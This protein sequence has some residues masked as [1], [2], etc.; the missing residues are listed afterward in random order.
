MEIDKVIDAAVAAIKDKSGRQMASWRRDHFIE[1]IYQAIPSL[2]TS[3]QLIFL[4]DK[5]QMKQVTV[6]RPEVEPMVIQQQPIQYQKKLYLIV[7]LSSGKTETLRHFLDNLGD[8]V[9]KRR[10]DVILVLVYF[11]QSIKE[12][13]AIFQP[14]IL[15]CNFKTY[16]IKHITSGNFSRGAA[17]DAGIQVIDQRANPLMFLCDVDV[18]FKESFLRR[19]MTYTESGKSV[20]YP[21]VFSLYN[22]TVSSYALRHIYNCVSSKYHIPYTSPLFK[23]DRILLQSKVS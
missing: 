12:L 3:Y 8:I 19:C 22:P 21:I 6:F 23:G 7:P 2:G 15:K 1:G 20:Y 17:L 14:F 11:G 4:N 5:Q 9:S 13:M 16:K 10:Y 18:I